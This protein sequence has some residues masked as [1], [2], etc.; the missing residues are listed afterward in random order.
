M[1]SVYM[2]MLKSAVSYLARGRRLPTWDIRL[3]ATCDGLRH[4]TQLLF[5]IASDTDMHT[6]DFDQLHDWLQTHQMPSTEL[7]PTRGMDRKLEYELIAPWSVHEKHGTGGRELEPYPLSDSERVILFFHG[8]SYVAGSPIAYRE[9]LGHLLG[10]LGTRAFVID[11][12]LAPRHPFP[13]QIHDALIA[14]S[15]LLGLGYKPHNIVLLGDSAGGHICLDLFL[16]LR[17]MSCGGGL[18]RL[19]AMVLLSPL[20]HLEIRGESLVGNA[21]LDYLI[22]IPISSPTMPLRLFYRPGA[23]CT[24]EYLRELEEP[25][26]SPLNGSLAE[27]PP[28]I[29]QCGAAELLVDDIRRLYEKLKADNPQDKPRIELEV[30]PDMVH[31]FHRF[32]FRAESKQAFQAVA[33]FLEKV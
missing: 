19:A 28:T 16:V 21:G 7:P 2:A 23:K 32:L 25:M 9:P 12:R 26:L 17:H 4:Y 11:Y 1:L 22:S 31:M 6:L 30:Y 14:F 10:H 5:P 3:Q 13:A 18:H 33:E 15:Y 20:P 29:I 27:F 8:G 24:A